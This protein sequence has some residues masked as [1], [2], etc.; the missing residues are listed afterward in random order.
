M[1]RVIPRKNYGA[2]S[3]VAASRIFASSKTQ[4]HYQPYLEKLAEICSGSMRTAMPDLPL[5]V[6]KSRASW[7]SIA[8]SGKSGIP[9]LA[10]VPWPLVLDPPY[11]AAGQ[12][13]L[14]SIIS[15][16]SASCF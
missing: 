1:A 11:A 16:I 9:I 8:P 10:A 14:P 6:I 5:G 3:F 7:R 12:N 15:Q 2:K 4:G 13:E